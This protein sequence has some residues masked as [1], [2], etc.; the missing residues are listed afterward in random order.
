MKVWTYM[1]MC[2]GPY[3]ETCPLME[4]ALLPEEPEKSP[5]RIWWGGVTQNQEV[6]VQFAKQLLIIQI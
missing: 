2:S 4:K 5:Q 6:P 3:G 1:Y